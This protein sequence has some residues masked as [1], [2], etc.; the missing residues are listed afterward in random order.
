MK[1]LR[2][3]QPIWH[4]VFWIVIYI[5]GVNIGDALSA[6]VGIPNIVTAP[7][8]IALSVGLLFYL[9]ANGW[10][11]HYGLTLPSAEGARLAWYYLPLA[12]MVL[13]LV[14]LG[15]NSALGTT[16]S[17]LII[18]L[19]LGVGFLE[20]LIFRGFLYRAILKTGGLT[21]AV[22]ISGVTFGVGHIVNLLR[23]YTGG[24]QLIQIVIGIAL[25]IVLA[26]LFALTGSI[27]PGVAF[28]QVLNIGGNLTQRDLAGDAV[29]M[30]VML[31]VC[32]IYG[33]H[34]VRALHKRGG[35][36]SATDTSQGMHYR[37]T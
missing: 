22:V 6:A 20:E 27:L 29:V 17:V 7:L 24:E 2:D 25:G 1:R 33:V 16:G 37:W 3:K 12:L 30:A 26:L 19:M 23:G 14:L 8:M 13:V 31:A 35:R 34:L 21:R 15:T 36:D 32:A 18:V 10:L 11:E 28:H 5:M 4:A 9:R